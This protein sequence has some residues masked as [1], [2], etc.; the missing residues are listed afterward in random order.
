M[1]TTSKSFLTNLRIIYF[2]LIGTMAL[3]ALVSFYL[4]VSGSVEVNADAKFVLMMRYVLFAVTPAAIGVGYVAFKQILSG[5]TRLPSLKEKLMRYQVAVLVRSAS[6]EIPG[7][8][9]SVITLIT[10]ELSFLLFTSIILM[11]FLMLI[12]GVGAIVQDLALSRKESAV[13][14]N[15]DS[16]LK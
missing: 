3:F 4:T 15:P 9:A 2:A 7:L 8:F 14:E 1:Q 13:L 5:A 10:G 11:L 6:L 12:P 16:I